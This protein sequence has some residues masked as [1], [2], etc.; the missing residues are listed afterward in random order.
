MF[1]KSSI[2]SLRNLSPL[3]TTA[4]KKIVSVPDISAMNLIVG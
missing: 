3:Y 1:A 2:D 4:S